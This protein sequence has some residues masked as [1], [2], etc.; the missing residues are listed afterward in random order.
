MGKF[1]KIWGYMTV[2]EAAQYL[3]LTYDAFRHMIERGQCP[4]KCH[5][6]G[7]LLFREQDVWT[8]DLQASSQKAKEK[9][10][11]HRKRKKGCYGSHIHSDLGVETYLAK[12]PMCKR[13]H[14]I[15]LRGWIGTGTIYKYCPECMRV[16]GLINPIDVDA[17][18]FIKT[19]IRPAN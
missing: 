6:N 12:C 10:Q 2:S 8:F 1:K 11:I 13:M 3:G 7:K 15:V 16:V 14:H 19:G 17:A 5:Q 9:A 4:E 18:H